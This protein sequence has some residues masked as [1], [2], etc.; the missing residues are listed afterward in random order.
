VKRGGRFARYSGTVGF[1][2]VTITPN[3]YGRTT[4]AIGEESWSQEQIESRDS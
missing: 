2:T 1:A 4:A 3:E